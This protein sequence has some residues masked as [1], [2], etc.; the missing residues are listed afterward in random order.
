MKEKDKFIDET[1]TIKD[2]IKQVDKTGISAWIAGKKLSEIKKQERFKF[3][4]NIFSDYCKKEFNISNNTANTYILI[5]KN[6][7]KKEVKD[8]FI[9]HLKILADLVHEPKNRSLIVETISNYSGK[10]IKEDIITAASFINTSKETNRNLVKNKLTEIFVENEIDKNRVLENE[11]KVQKFGKPLESK[12]ISEI[13]MEKEPINEMGVVGLFCLIFP[14]FKNYF[15]IHNEKIAFKSIKYIQAPFPDACILCEVKDNKKTETELL[16][17]FE[18][19]SFEYIRHK[20]HL[21][22]KKCDMIICWQD[23]A[24]TKKSRL[25][26]EIVKNMPPIFELKGFLET[27]NIELID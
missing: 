4:Y 23:N 1:K 6:Y 14:Y 24:K 16:I 5:F 19:E 7:E 17:E 20:H 3:R 8:L 11:K 15:N 26:M 22:N 2:L 21:S 25:N 18:F 27:G 9:S 12:F 10:I 13:K